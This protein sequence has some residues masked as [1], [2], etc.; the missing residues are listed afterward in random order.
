MRVG[1]CQPLPSL[2]PPPFR[3]CRFSLR[4]PRRHATLHSSSGLRDFAV[5]GRHGQPDDIFR[6]VPAFACAVPPFRSTRAET[7]LHNSSPFGGKT[8]DAE[9]LY[10][11]KAHTFHAHLGRL[12][13]RDPSGYGDGM[14]MCE[15]VPQRP[16]VSVDLTGHVPIT[17]L[18]ACA[19]HPD[20]I[21]SRGS[22][23]IHDLCGGTVVWAYW[24]E[25]TVAATWKTPSGT[26]QTATQDG[27]ETGGPERAVPQSAVFLLHVKGTPGQADPNCSATTEEFLA[28]TEIFHGTRRRVMLASLAVILAGATTVVLVLSP[29]FRREMA[30]RRYKR[31][32]QQGGK[33]EDCLRYLYPYLGFG[34]N[35]PSVISYYASG[36]SNEWRGRIV[37]DAFT[38]AACMGRRGRYADAHAALDA[39]LKVYYEPK[40]LAEKATLYARVGRWKEALEQQEEAIRALCFYGVSNP[41]LVEAN[42]V[43]EVHFRRMVIYAKRAGDLAAFARALRLYAFMAGGSISPEPWACDGD[44]LSLKR[45]LFPREDLTEEEKAVVR[46]VLEECRADTR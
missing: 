7:T 41:G 27:R 23:L 32:L 39:V 36:P 31:C 3:A 12:L 2:H 35:G 10:H 14:T 15:V 13:Q 30:W 29:A 11:Y 46:Q 43:P 20:R 9:G 45:D 26:T 34:E 22:T 44:F 25:Y 16:H 37:E 18:A 24:I 33:F 28:M 4:P 40:I 21:R 5:E 17:S 1:G 19:K 8:L 42:L 6:P 38:Y